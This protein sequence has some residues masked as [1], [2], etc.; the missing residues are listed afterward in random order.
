M[1]EGLA[2]QCDRIRH[3][4]DVEEKTVTST[5]EELLT[6]ISS[7][8]NDQ[9]A[10][11][12]S[13]TSELDNC[14][15]GLNVL[16]RSIEDT[17]AKLHVLT[18]SASEAANEYMA[19]PNG[20]GKQLENQYVQ[21]RAISSDVNLL[22]DAASISFFTQTV[23]GTK[24]RFVQTELA[25]EKSMD[26]VGEAVNAIEVRIPAFEEIRNAL[27]PRLP[28]LLSDHLSETIHDYKPTGTTPMRKNLI[29]P[30]DVPRTGRHSLLLSKFRQ[31]LGPP[32]YDYTNVAGHRG[33]DASPSLLA[34]RLSPSSALD[35][36]D[37]EN[38]PGRRSG[39]RYSS[40]VV[41][42]KFVLK[43]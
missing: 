19:S 24:D 16:S 40:G 23:K 5:A 17:G 30:K 1:E 8:S 22:D 34:E 37:Q 21:W 32:L 33:T 29:Y 9:K 10:A 18:E 26:K 36:C 6:L 2:A 14:V 7:T 13:I 12:S 39:S 20:L 35:E 38:S 42:V 15:A 4:A 3:V 28:A 31:E 43:C 41:R 11:V 27:I 25:V